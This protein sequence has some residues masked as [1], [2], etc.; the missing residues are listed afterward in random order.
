MSPTPFSERLDLVV[1][2]LG[3][4]FRAVGE[5]LWSHPEM[6]QLYPGVLYRM[7]CETRASVGLMEAAVDRLETM[8]GDPLAPGLLAYLRG[9]I[10][11]ERGHDDW[12]LDSLE[13]LGIPRAEVWRRRPP[14]SVAAIVGEQ[15]YWIH[16]H[17]P[18]ALL[19]YIKVVEND[20][21]PVET[22]D[23]VREKTGFP[24]A[25]FRY[26]YGHAH[27]ELKHNGDLD[28]VLDALPLS[29]EDRELIILNASRTLEGTARK[30]E[31]LLAEYERD[32]V[33]LLAAA[34]TGRAT[35]LLLA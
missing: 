27:L 30:A 22:I 17:H 8:T 20:P 34:E 25:A 19:G 3:A 6:A 9:L 2:L 29:E 7:H 14:A 28:R 12:V 11:E 24:R 33:D 10:P 1:S 21:A 26:Y 15:Y 31:E 13:A 16:H 18:V 4:R 23:A 32:R 35:A 5:R